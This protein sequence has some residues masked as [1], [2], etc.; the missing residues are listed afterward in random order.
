MIYD[1]DVRLIREKALA[2]ENQATTYAEL[3]REMFSEKLTDQSLSVFAGGK[4][5][6]SEVTADCRRLGSHFAGHIL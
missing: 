4:P 1:D 5:M 2:R 3:L 6:R